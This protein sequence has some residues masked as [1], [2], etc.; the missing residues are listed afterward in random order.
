M[1]VTS[2]YDELRLGSRLGP[3]QLLVAV[4]QGGMARVWAARHLPTRRIV[5]VKTIRPDSPSTAPTRSCSR[6]GALR[7]VA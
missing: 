6:R 2:A 1:S 3:Y 7:R 5:A 4:A